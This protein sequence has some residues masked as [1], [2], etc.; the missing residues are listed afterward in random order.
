MAG[1]SGAVLLAAMFLPWYGRTARCVEAPC[2]SQTLDAWGAFAVTDLVVL[3]AAL[4][5]LASWVTTA[6]YR[7]VA[8]PVAVSSL[9]AL[10]GTLALVVVVVRAA[11]P[12]DATTRLSGLWVGLVAVLGVAM[13]GW[14]AVR[15]ESYGFWPSQD[16][17]AGHPE[18]ARSVEVLDLP[19]PAPGGETERR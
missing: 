4:F 6:A 19:A 17:A 10:V 13:G 14:L 16:P 2:P 7:T 1:A 3:L 15:D 8:V 11:V 5:A 18:R 12:P 9:A